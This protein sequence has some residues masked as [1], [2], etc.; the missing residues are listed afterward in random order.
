M[1]VNINQTPNS[2]VF[3]HDQ[4]FKAHFGA[5][6]SVTPICLPGDGHRPYVDVHF[7]GGLRLELSPSAMAEIC[8]RGVEALAKLP[9]LPD[10]HDA[11]GGA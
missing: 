3:N 6:H 2:L 7:I 11:V 5:V 4:L 10:I 8:R 1:T 9:Y